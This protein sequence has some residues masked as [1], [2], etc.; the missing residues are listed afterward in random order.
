MTAP[1]LVDG[2]ASSRGWLRVELSWLVDELPG[3]NNGLLGSLPKPFP[4]GATLLLLRLL[5]DRAIWRGIP[6]PS[7]RRIAYAVGWTEG[8][9]RTLLRHEEQ[10][11]APRDLPRWAQ[12][13]PKHRQAAPAAGGAPP[14]PTPEPEPK[15]PRKR[16]S[17]ATRPVPT[18][19][20]LPLRR[21]PWLRELGEEAL[22]DVVRRCVVAITEEAD[23]SP[24]TQ[25]AAA[26]YVI[27][28]LAL[29]TRAGEPVDVEAF[30]AD[31][32]LVARAARESRHIE[33]S[34]WVRGIG[35][36]ERTDGSRV[37][38][39]VLYAD[40]WP[41]RLQLAR[42]E[43]ALRGRELAGGAGGPPAAANPSNLEGELADGL[44]EADDV[45]QRLRE[46]WARD[47]RALWRRSAEGE[48]FALG[49]NPVDEARRAHA[50]DQVVRVITAAPL[51][52]VVGVPWF[53]EDLDRQRMMLAWMLGTGP[54]DT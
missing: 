8:K 41:Q 29:R 34:R 20:P 9:V 6:F 38:R 16:E 51:E 35:M 39:C 52:D 11:V 42:Q 21:A 25:R 24:E 53:V 14:A 32:E 26:I 13:R 54:P 23:P 37:P 4:Q 44:V 3:E 15:P 12:V 46:A 7:R 47:P 19:W 22:R 40:R 17:K 18:E 48:G 43:L 27:R 30:V 1:S 49:D 10:W 28:V 5:A 2:L 45:L 31:V 50:L 36:A 33:F